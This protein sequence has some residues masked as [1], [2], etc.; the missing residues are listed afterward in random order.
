VEPKR[1]GWARWLM[2]QFQHLLAFLVGLAQ[3]RFAARRRRAHR[4]STEPE[5]A[6]GGVGDGH[7]PAGRGVAVLRLRVENFF[8]FFFFF[9]KA[10]SVRLDLEDRL[11][12]DAVEQVVAAAADRLAFLAARVRG[13]GELARGYFGAVAGDD[14][15]GSRWAGFAPGATRTAFA[16][17]AFGALGTA[18]ATRTAFAGFSLGSRCTGGA[19]FTRFTLFAAGTAGAGVARLALQSLFAAGSVR[20][21]FARQAAR[22]MRAFFAL[23]SGRTPG[24]GGQFAFREV[25]K[26]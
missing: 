25:A 21:I 10:G 13:F 16:R 11:G 24:A 1:G 3:F 22:S 8:F 9:F 26:N 12:G 4:V 15:G 19:P 18:F 20:S 23:W 2:R 5:L 14:F 17:F 7:G 6:A